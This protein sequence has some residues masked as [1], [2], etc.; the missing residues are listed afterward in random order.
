MANY[1]IS[2]SSETYADNS[3]ASSAITSAGA[4]ISKTYSFALTYKISATAEQLAAIAGVTD[5]YDADSS[6]SITPMVAN[7][8]HI[9]YT[10]DLGGVTAYNPLNTGTGQ[11]VYL[12]DSGL[13]ATHSEFSSATI[14]NLHTAF[15]DDSDVSDYGDEVAGHGTVVGSLIVGNTVGGAP[16][17]TLQNVKLFSGNEGSITVG[18][19]IDALDAVLEHHLANDSTK[20]KVVAMAW[21][22]PQNNFVDAKVQE[23]DA[24]NLLC[25]VAAGNNGGDVATYSPAGVNRVITVGSFNRDLEVSNFTNTPWAGGTPNSGFINYGA[26]LDIFALGVDVDAAD[27]GTGNA[28]ITATGTSTSTGVVAGIATHYIEREPTKSSD[29]IK[30]I[31]MTEGHYTGTTNL[32]FDTSGSIDYSSVYKSIITTEA[33]NELY[34]T[35][36]PSGRILDIAVNS[37]ATVDLGLNSS[38]ANVSVLD[39]APAPSWITVNT[40][41][42]IVSVDTNGLDANITPGVFLFAMRGTVSGETVVEEF[43]VGV[44]ESSESEL[45]EA[46]SYYYDATDAEYDQVVNY[47][48][49][50]ASEKP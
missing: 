30:D 9:K 4:T 31:M 34:L 32:I 36:L 1:I 3:A 2:L 7:T 22:I 33:Q 12:I 20:V 42:G 39:F 46:S 38:A 25:V 16:N 49:A 11:T 27:A 10:L 43:S 14:N 5:S 21:T 18:A 13:D 26:E 17:A 24:N 6:V 45:Q 48:A 19:I 50:P 28:Y 35:T 29:E 37:T 44:Y 40:G 8:D 15:A 41:T 47:Q 23:L